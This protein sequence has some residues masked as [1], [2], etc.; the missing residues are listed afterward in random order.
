MTDDEKKDDVPEVQQDPLHPPVEA[1]PTPPEPSPQVTRERETIHEIRYMEPEKKKKSRL[2]TLGIL[3]V[4]LLIGVVAVVATL[5]VVIYPPVDGAT[6][7]YTTTYDVWFPLGKAVTV[8][9]IDMVALSTEDEMMIAVDGATEKLEVGENKLISERRAV[10]KTFGL[11]VVDT[12]FQIY[13]NYR[14]LS[15]PRTANFHLAVRTSEQVPQFIV[16]MLLP[17][18][19]QAV[20][21]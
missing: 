21:A 9:G 8:G 11:T 6:Y 18:D 17:R 15:D 7:P 10:V 2:K 20:P 19:I 16:G 4:I 14:G 5:N 3:L 1:P 13:L 12:N